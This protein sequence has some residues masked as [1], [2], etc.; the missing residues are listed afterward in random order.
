VL[1]GQSSELFLAAAPHPVKHKSEKNGAE[2]NELKATRNA[3]LG[4]FHLAQCAK[5]SR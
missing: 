5:F 3:G 1:E 2:K 4:K